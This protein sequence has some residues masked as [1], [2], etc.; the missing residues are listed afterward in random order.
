MTIHEQKHGAVMVIAPDGP[1]VQSDA[2][3]FKERA[4]AAFSRSLGRLVIDA[5]KVPFVD[6]K[7]LEALLDV[8]DHLGQSGQAIKLCAANKTIREV[9]SLTELAPLFEQYDDVTTA[10]RSFL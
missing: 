8:N 3:R 4:V 6:S 1:L 5:S 7:G 2:E 10:V 9:L